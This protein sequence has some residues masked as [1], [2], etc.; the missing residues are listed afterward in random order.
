MT[1]SSTFGRRDVTIGLI[2]G[3]ILGATQYSATAQTPAAPKIPAAPP[4]NNLDYALV[5]K[6]SNKLLNTWS[7]RD[8]FASKTSGTPFTPNIL[9]AIAC[10]ET[11]RAW[12]NSKFCGG[13]SRD[14]ILRLLVLDHPKHARKAFPSDTAEFEKDPD[15]GHLAPALKAASDAAFSAA[16]GTPVFDGWDRTGEIFRGWGLF[17]YDLQNI[18]ND[19]RKKLG[20]VAF[21]SDKDGKR[22]VDHDGMPDIGLWGNAEACTAR[23][24]QVLTSKYRPGMSMVQLFTRYNGGKPYGFVV[25]R[26][27]ELINEAYPDTAI[28]R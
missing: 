28:A 24:V 3:V 20:D 7:L 17:Q 8:I 6:A 25:A 18:R 11:G 5:V 9:C 21:W 26:M 2:G 1:R 23:A 22:D 12:F 27:L 19:G 4:G 14:E 16:K 13:R 10:Q 15:L